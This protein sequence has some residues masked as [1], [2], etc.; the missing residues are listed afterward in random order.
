MKGNQ[1]KLGI[2]MLKHDL[3]AKDVAVILNKTPGSVARYTCGA[4][5]FS[6]KHLATLKDHL[7]RSRMIEED[8]SAEVFAGEYLEDW[9]EL[10]FVEHGINF[11]SNPMLTLKV[12]TK[13]LVL[14]AGGTL[15]ITDKGNK[16]TINNVSISNVEELISMFK[17]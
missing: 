6:D 14:F 13:T 10:G 4:R 7:R 15:W 3:K 12:G 5:R 17:K 2:L 1:L 9:K 8:L 16:I 11:L